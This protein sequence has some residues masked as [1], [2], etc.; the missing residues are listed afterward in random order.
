ML[1]R[2]WRSAW[3]RRAAPGGGAA[4]QPAGGPG[5]E[6]FPGQTVLLG[7]PAARQ[8]RYAWPRQALLRESSVSHTRDAI[9]YRSLRFFSAQALESFCRICPS[10]GWG[11][12][13][14]Q[15]EAVGENLWVSGKYLRVYLI[16]TQNP[17]GLRAVKISACKYVLSRFDFSC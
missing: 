14:D 8:A 9:F 2:D 3:D 17:R 15:A 12:G 6:A 4:W 1:S 10:T 5:A 7:Q 16:S 11:R 13:Q